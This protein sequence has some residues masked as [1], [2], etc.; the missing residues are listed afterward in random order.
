M[1]GSSQEDLLSAPSAPVARSDPSAE[2]AADT[3]QGN[4]EVPP[5]VFFAL[6]DERAQRLLRT[7]PRD[8]MALHSG[9]TPT[10]RV[11]PIY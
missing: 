11:S 2:L 4:D 5:A 10:P 9:S 1:T 8:R 7:A 3:D 6:G